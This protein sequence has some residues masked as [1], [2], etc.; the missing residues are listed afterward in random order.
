VQIPLIFPGD[1]AEEL[2]TA[3]MRGGTMS[4]CDWHPSKAEVA[5][6]LDE[7]RPII[8]EMSRKEN[9]ALRDEVARRFLAIA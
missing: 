6:I 2:G 3:Q 4:D 9:E 7:L 8:S 5:H 1:G